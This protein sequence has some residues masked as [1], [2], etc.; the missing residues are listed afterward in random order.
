[1]SACRYALGSWP[2]RM[3]RIF[4]SRYAFPI[5]SL[6]LIMHDPALP[7]PLPEEGIRDGLGIFGRPPRLRKTRSTDLRRK[8]SDRPLVPRSP[9]FPVTELSILSSSQ[10][11]MSVA[12]AHHGQA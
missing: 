12:H 9:P 11:L 6:L 3:Y 1:M 4:L 5:I 10:T 7:F 8:P 2:H